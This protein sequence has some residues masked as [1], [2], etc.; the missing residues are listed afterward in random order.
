MKA[1]DWKF[2]VGPCD[3]S[4]CF[5]AWASLPLSVPQFPQLYKESA[6]LPQPGCCVSLGW[7][8]DISEP[9]FL[10]LGAEACLCSLR[11]GL[12]GEMGQISVDISS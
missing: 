7:S 6:G 1:L 10:Y 11:G 12:E 3:L 8:L 2:S 9:Q 5:V 4:H